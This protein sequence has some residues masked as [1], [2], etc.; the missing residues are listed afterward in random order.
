MCKIISL[1]FSLLLSA[2]ISC[3]KTDTAGEIKAKMIFFSGPVTLNGTIPNKDDMV[4][5]DDVIETGNNGTCDILV[6]TKSLF[7]LKGNSKLIYSINKEKQVLR[8]EKGWLAGI[9]RKIFTKEGKY[10]IKTPTVSASIRGTS[11]CIK[12][13]NPR[14]TY[15]CV[16]NG[17]ISLQGE[18]TEK[19]TAAHHS[20]RRFKTD[21]SGKIL[22]DSNPG[23]LYH[24]DDTIEALAK[25]INEQINWGKAY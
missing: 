10:L 2:C 15:F 6:G 16:C 23:L 1:I 22:V 8:L 7:R 5:A 17:T 4:K 18:E 24:G 25:K 12:V 14:S 13:E 9:T 3:K 19:V 20:A 21:N 11:Y